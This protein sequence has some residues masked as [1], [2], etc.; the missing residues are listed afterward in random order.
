MTAAR[1]LQESPMDRLRAEVLRVRGVAQEAHDKNV[2][3][4][5]TWVISLIDRERNRLRESVR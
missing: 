5:L 1:E 4:T 2:V 3:D